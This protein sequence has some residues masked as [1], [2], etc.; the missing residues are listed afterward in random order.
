MPRLFH[1][2]ETPGITLFEPRPSP[3]F[4]EGIAGEVVFAI[5]ER[6]VAGYSTF[7]AA[8]FPYPHAQRTCL[9][10]AAPGRCLQ[11]H[12]MAFGVFKR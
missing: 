2:S 4:F 10:P 1:I 12:N 6:L 3:S 11:I 7:I 5:E 9:K 8:A